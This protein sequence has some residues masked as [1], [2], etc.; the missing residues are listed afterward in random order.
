MLAINL[1]QVLQSSIVEH[2]N[3]ELTGELN[4]SLPTR[5]DCTA[6]VQI[7]IEYSKIDHGIEILA[8]GNALLNPP[9]DRCQETFSLNIPFNFGQ[10]VT[11]E[12]ILRL[13][14]GIF[15]LNDLVKEAILVNIPIKLLCKED[16]QGLCDN[17]GVNL[18]NNKCNCNK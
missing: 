2:V 7:K 16:C 3:S 17:C 10:F 1:R 9:C 13:K 15:A 6:K 8:H 5:I 12:D 11:N 4:L 18:N 14:H